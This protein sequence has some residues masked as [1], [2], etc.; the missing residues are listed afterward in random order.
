MDMF[1]SVAH[2]VRLQGIPCIVW[3]KVRA[4]GDDPYPFIFF[5]AC[6]S[7]P[8]NGDFFVFKGR[9]AA[10]DETLFDGLRVYHNPHATHPLDWRVFQEP[11]ALQAVCVN[12]D[13]HEWRYWLDR[14]PL[15]ARNLLT[16]NVPDADAAQLEELMKKADD[17]PKGGWYKV[18]FTPGLIEEIA[19]L[20]GKVRGSGPPASA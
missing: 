7:D 16:M 6:R 13:T 2:E 15:A 10:Y 8:R 12:P 4:L 9:K 5:Q 17:L 11:G 1:G 3:G 18:P 14:P 20:Q 19:G